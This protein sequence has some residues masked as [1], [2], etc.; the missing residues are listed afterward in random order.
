V[1]N[2][3]WLYLCWMCETV[4]WGGGSRWSP[5][6]QIWSVGRLPSNMIVFTAAIYELIGRKPSSGL[7]CNQ[8]ICH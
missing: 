5:V 8:S 6:G 1:S 4:S 7:R 3:R 2:I